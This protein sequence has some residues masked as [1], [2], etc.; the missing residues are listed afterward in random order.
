VLLRGVNDRPAH[1]RELVQLLQGR[2]AYVNLIPFNEVDGLPYRRPADD[3]LKAFVSIL[4][5]AGV[6]VHVRKRKGGDI[7][8]ACGQLRRA[9]QAKKNQPRT[10]ETLAVS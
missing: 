10:Q 1:A 9:E 8:A 5:Q 6:F 4:R 3:D 7:S 2:K